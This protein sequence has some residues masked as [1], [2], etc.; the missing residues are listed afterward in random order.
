MEI[1]WAVET[2][3]TATKINPK[4]GKVIVYIH[5]KGDHLLFSEGDEYIDR[6]ELTPYFVREYGYK[7]AC[8]ARRNFSFKNPENGKFWSGESRIIRLWVRKDGTVHIC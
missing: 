2:I 8:D 6:N 4:A 7:R 3:L 1:Y 5:G